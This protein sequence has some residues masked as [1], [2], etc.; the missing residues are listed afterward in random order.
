MKILVAVAVVALAS[1]RAL[2]QPALTAPSAP[3]ITTSEWYGWQVLAADGAALGIG[4]ATEQP[5]IAL[6]WVGTGAAVH[7]Y[8]HHYGRAVLSVGMRIGLPILGMALGESSA[9][10]CT[11]DFCD[12]GAVL[13]GGLVGM[14]AAEVID[15][16]ESTDEHEVLPAP[17]R[18][19]TPIAGIRHGGG[20]LGIA[21]RF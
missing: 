14:G 18:S 8:H 10:G 1:T 13:A 16:V 2:A 9:K 3:P 5:E 7:A 15:L 17:S 21:A 6:G 4:I 12:L 19:W 20:T 11:G